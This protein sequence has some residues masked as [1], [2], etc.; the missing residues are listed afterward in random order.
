MTLHNCD[1]GLQVPECGTC[2]CPPTVKHI[3]MDCVDFSDV[4]NKQFACSI[5][6]L[7]EN[8]EALT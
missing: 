4:R 8:V 1:A 6:D 5:K 2:Q 7:I 3:L